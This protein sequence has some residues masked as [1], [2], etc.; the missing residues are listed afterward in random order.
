MAVRDRITF[1]NTLKQCIEHIQKTYP[2]SNQAAKR[3]KIA[4]SFSLHNCGN[5]PEMIEEFK[6][7]S[8]QNYPV[9]I[10]IQEASRNKYSHSF[11]VV[12][13]EKGLE[14]GLKYEGFQNIRLLFQE[15]INH[16]EQLYKLYAIGSEWDIVIKTSVP[17]VKVTQ[18]D[19]FFFQTK[20]KFEQSSFTRFTKDN[21]VEDEVF[22]IITR[23]VGRSFDMTL[24]GI[25]MVLE[26]TTGNVFLIDVNYFGSYE[27]LN[28]MDPERAF[29]KLI[30]ETWQKKKDLL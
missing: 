16:N 5:I 27:G 2:E 8:H 9:I 14:E 6:E 26:E 15:L 21:L 30:K 10:K 17:M 13:N 23:E 29:K 24:F 7:F 12:N 11:Y 18:G 25:D 1:D 28:K 22:D 19:Y 3:I 4:K 20:M